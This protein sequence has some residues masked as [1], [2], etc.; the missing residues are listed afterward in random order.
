MTKLIFGCGYLGGRVAQRWR[1][2]GHA[3]VAVTRSP[4]R[5]KRLAQA[6]LQPRI[7][8]VTQPASLGNLPVADSVLF[9]VGFDRTAGHTIETVYAGGLANVLATLP[10]MTRRFVYIS[11]TGVYG[12]AGGAWVSEATPPGPV[13]PGGQASL[14]AE[15]ALDRSPFADRA[16]ILRLGGIFGPGRVPLIDRLRAGQPIAA[17]SHGWLNLIHVDDAAA[18]VLA[19]EQWLAASVASRRHRPRG[20]ATDAVAE[21]MS[22]DRPECHPRWPFLLNVTDGVPVLRTDYYREIARQIGAPPPTF[23][24]PAPG[25][26]RATRA[27]SNRRI[28]T[29]RLRETLTVA[30]AYPSYREALAAILR[31]PPDGPSRSV[32][33]P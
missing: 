17:A 30:F 11:T 12:D 23:E 15:R 7:A 19:V 28:G 29:A 32:P 31:P 16:A 6:G 5:A 21:Q 2:A 22:A 14:A 3:V 13:R 10:A 33:V 26:P 20:A 27:R 25:A 8:D 9:A 1:R 18:V 24:P 4:A